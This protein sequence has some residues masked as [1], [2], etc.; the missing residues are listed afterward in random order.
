MDV[1]LTPLPGGLES[2]VARARV[3][4]VL[5]PSVPRRFVVKRLEDVASWLPSLGCWEPVARRR[6]DTLMRA[7]LDA[8][9]V[10]RPHNEELRRDYWRACAS[11]GLSGAIRYHLAVLADVS[12]PE[13]ARASS[14]HALT[15]WERV[16]KRAAPLVSTSAGR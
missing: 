10:R 5:S 8:R 4:G 7:Y 14:R 13:A 12:A 6:H 15:A 9:S 2:L 3:A 1:E 11:N 16:V